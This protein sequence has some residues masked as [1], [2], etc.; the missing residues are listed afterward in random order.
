MRTAVADTALPVP[1]MWTFDGPFDRCLADA[2][3]TLRRAVVLVGDVSRVAL[4]ID[5][6]LPALR[7]RVRCGDAVQPAWG[8]FLENIER[9]ELPASPHVRHVRADAPL[10]TLLIAY[11]N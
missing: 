9:Y 1:L 10:L 8:R 5:L 3:D 11:R 7:R 2:E 4:V 6:S